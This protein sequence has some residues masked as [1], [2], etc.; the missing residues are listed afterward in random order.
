MNSVLAGL[1]VFKKRE[2]NLSMVSLTEIVGYL[3]L[4]SLTSLKALVTI[5]PKAYSINEI[6]SSILDKLYSD[7][8]SV[9]GG[10][11]TGN[12]AFEYLNG[13]PKNFYSLYSVSNEYL[14]S[15]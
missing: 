8:L 9:G 11:L 13:F 2:N 6:E 5:Y 10:I 4:F 3:S 1:F 14:L 12:T 15:L 7:T